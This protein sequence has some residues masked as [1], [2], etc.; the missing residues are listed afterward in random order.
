MAS[1]QSIRRARSVSVPETLPR[2]LD[3]RVGGV[4]VFGAAVAG[5]MNLAYDGPVLA[6]A[7]FVLLVAIGAGAHV[8]GERRL[9][10]LAEQLVSAWIEAGVSVESVCGPADGPRTEWVVQTGDGPIRVGGLAL[11]PLSRLTVTKDG[12]SK[13]VPASTVAADPEGHAERYRHELLES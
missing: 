8:L 3:A 9:R 12:A 7:A 2:A 5:S 6:A 11:V 10:G 4:I 13:T 1:K